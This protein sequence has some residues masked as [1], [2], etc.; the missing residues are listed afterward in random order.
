MKRSLRRRTLPDDMK[1]L[2]PAICLALACFTGLSKAETV[3]LPAQTPAVSADI[4]DTWQAEADGN[5]ILAESPDKVTT[6]YFEV[7][8]DAKEMSGV[9]QESLAWL[10]KK[11]GLEVNPATKTDKEFVAAGRQWNRISWNAE[12][13]QWG[14]S[15]IGFL[16][17]EV[18][19]G[20]VL[21]ITFWVSKK[22]SEKSLE[23]MD[24][25]LS[26]VKSIN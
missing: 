6:V 23:T 10:T 14:A 3:K 26:S 8:T 2:L 20:K 7:V 22:D 19:R 17:T 16:L 21:I 12:S 15:I 13:K 4:P 5:G 11:H 18:G 24:K 25:I 1:R 9:V